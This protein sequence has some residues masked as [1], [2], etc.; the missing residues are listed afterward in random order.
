MHCTTRTR[1]KPKSLEH[2]H[3]PMFIGPPPEN[4]SCCIAIASSVLTLS[5][6]NID[7]PRTA[8]HLSTQ[9][10][11]PTSHFGSVQPPPAHHPPHS[12]SLSSLFSKP[13]ITHHIPPRKSKPSTASPALYP[14]IPILLPRY[15][16]TAP[17]NAR[18]D[19]KTPRPRGRGSNRV[20]TYNLHPNPPSMTTRHASEPGTYGRSG[21][22]C[23]SRRSARGV[24]SPGKA[25]WNESCGVGMGD[26]RGWR[27]W[28]GE[29]LTVGGLMRWGGAGRGGR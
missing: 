23:W 5:S 16:T 12:L 6:Q 29:A 8:S 21:G 26:L 9:L 1:A 17:R 19:H 11:P 27:S 14:P 24:S 10:N 2:F 18:A 4:S 3:N 13:Q 20:T 22:W 15:T 25:A 7:R 28:R